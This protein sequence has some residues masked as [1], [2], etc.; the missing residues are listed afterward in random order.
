MSTA[1]GAPTIAARRAWLE[2]AEA[3]S[4]EML[5]GARVGDWERVRDLDA[6]RRPLVEEAF[7]APLDDEGRL[8]LEPVLRRLAELNEA[9]IACTAEARDEQGAAACAAGDGRRAVA[10]YRAA[11]G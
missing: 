11:A 10:A 1:A 7:V 6:A 9:L 2:R 3:L 5:A 8:G 4:R